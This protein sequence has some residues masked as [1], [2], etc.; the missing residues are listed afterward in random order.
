MKKI[1]EVDEGEGLEALLGKE[2]MVWCANY[3]YAGKLAGVNECDIML[4]GAKVVYET[5][6]L[7]EIGFSDAQALPGTCWYIRTALI[8]S[9]GEN[10]VE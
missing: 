10:N 8:E 2:I 6:P 9:Y 3:I 1:I 4:T 5:G 7:T